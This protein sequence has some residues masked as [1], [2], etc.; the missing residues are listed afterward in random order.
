MKINV[1]ES[2]LVYAMSLIQWEE[3]EEVAVASD[4]NLSR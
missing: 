3:K 1:F 2:G 4:S